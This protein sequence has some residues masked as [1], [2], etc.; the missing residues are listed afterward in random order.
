MSY[1]ELS[2]AERATIQIRLSNNLSQRKIAQ[3][4]NHSPHHRS[5]WSTVIVVCMTDT[6][7]MK[8]SP[9]KVFCFSRL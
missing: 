1:Y 8:P 2:V 3:L 9:F 5:R 7:P 6:S 4:L